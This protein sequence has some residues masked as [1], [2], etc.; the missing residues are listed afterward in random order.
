MRAAF[1]SAPGVIELREVPDPTPGP[2]DIVLRVRACGICGSDLHWFRG[3]LPPPAVCPGHEFAGEVAQCGSGVTNVRAGDT[4][5]V[6]PLVVCREC[7][8]CRTGRPQLCPHLRI[9]GLSRPGGFA[10]LVLVPAYAVFPLPAAM[11]CEIG[12]LCEPLA[13]CVH[14]AR[15][16]RVAIGDRVL[17]LGAGSVG[18]L[19]VLAARAAGASEVVV[20]ARHPHQAGM[21][22]R[23]GAAKVFAA[24][25]DGQRECAAYAADHPIDVVIESVGG[26]A[27]TIGEALQ[28]VRPGGRVAVLGIFATAPALPA[29][30]MVA[31]EVRLVGS[32]LY[33]HTG[34]RADFDVALELLERQRDC[35]AALITHRIGLDAI[36]SAFDAASDRR[37]GA[38]KVTVTP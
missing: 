1:C 12:A 22:R 20:S 15:L 11:P 28:M 36:Q 21:A 13:V 34:A 14:A 29:L 26:S 23:L 4:V 8:Y 19:A 27:D 2:G 5:A 18:L 33:D 32:M 17:I 35:A 24:T 10:D 9:L 3:G 37:G 25:D 31:K 16:A 6:E 38:I 30:P 7:G